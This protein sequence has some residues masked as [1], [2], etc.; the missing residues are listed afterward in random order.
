MPAQRF[1]RTIADRRYVIETALVDPDRWCACLV[2]IPGGPSALMPFY[3]ETPERA[4]EHLVDW[5]ALVHHPT[6]PCA[7]VQ[8]S[9]RSETGA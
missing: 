1:E 9:R 8:A 7:I 3:G 5:L 2:G 4:V 6:G